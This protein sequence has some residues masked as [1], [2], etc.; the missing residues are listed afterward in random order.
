MSQ[1]AP[2]QQRV[3][4]EKKDLDEKIE[5]IESFTGGEIFKSMPIRDRELLVEQRDHMLSYSRVLG[6]R[7]SRF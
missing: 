1:L 6:A 7:I 4:D 5:K 2:Y 3:V